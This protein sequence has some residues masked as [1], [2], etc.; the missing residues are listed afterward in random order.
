[1]VDQIATAPAP[2]LASRGFPLHYFFWNSGT[3]HIHVHPY[4]LFIEKERDV[5][6]PTKRNQFLYTHP[7]GSHAFVQ[8]AVTEKNTLATPGGKAWKHPRAAFWQRRDKPWASYQ[9]KSFGARKVED[10]KSPWE[11]VTDELKSLFKVL[12]QVLLVAV[13]S[14]Q[15]LVVEQAFLVV[16][17]GQVSGNVDDVADVQPLHGVQVLSV[18]LIAKEQEGQDGRQLR[19][20][21]VRGGGD[22]LR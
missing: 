17:E 9:S 14:R 16:V 21:D 13:S 20:L 19:I 3:E 7:R 2:A 11:I 18:L 22:G 10:E 4:H 8:Q 12:P 1:M 6:F 5:D 15:P